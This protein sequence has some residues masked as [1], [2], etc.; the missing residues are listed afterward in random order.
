MLRNDLIIKLSEQDNEC[1]TVDVN[2]ILVDVDSVAQDRGNIVLVLDPE[3]LRATLTQVASGKP[4]PSGTG[5][6]LPG[7]V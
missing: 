3:E 5:Q 7:G 6:R 1:V 2:G 4:D